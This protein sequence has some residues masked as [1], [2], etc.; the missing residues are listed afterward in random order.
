M[1]VRTDESTGR[2]HMMDG[3]IDRYKDG[4][5]DEWMDIRTDRWMD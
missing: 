1:D 4:R 5:M 2:M 3:W